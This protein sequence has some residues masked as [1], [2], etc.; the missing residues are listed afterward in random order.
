MFDYYHVDSLIKESG[1]F[2]IDLLKTIIGT[3]LGFIGAF[4]LTQW[5]GKKQT[6][7]ERNNKILRYKERLSYLI[8]LI[9]SSIKIINNQ[10]N[11]FESLAQDIFQDPVEQHLLNIIASTDLQRLQNMDTEEV[12]HAYYQIVPESQDKSVDYKNIYGSIDFLYLR[13]KQAIE[14]TDK[15][16]N[17]LHRDQMYIKE[18]VEKL[19][20]DLYK[21]IKHIETENKEFKTLP[22]YNFLVTHHQ[23]YLKLIEEEAKLGILEESFLVPFGNELRK[24]YANEDFFG[25]LN[26]LATKAIIRFN[27]ITRNSIE[28]AAELCDIR[29]EMSNSINKLTDIKEKLTSH[30]TAY[31]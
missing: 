2:W 12:F 6:I 27:H 16:V 26:D 24:T 25:D 8:Q 13:H 4:Y 30:N 9:D 29:K 17:F 19:S 21:W 1:S 18:T 15:H 31:K 23:N 20:N 14:S 7:R 3:L 22:K 11:N 28:F 10:L 5:T